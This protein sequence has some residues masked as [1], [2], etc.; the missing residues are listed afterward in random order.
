[1]NN[2]IEIERKYLLHNIDI[3]IGKYIIKKIVIYQSYHESCG[4]EI[5]LR[6]EI[7]EDESCS[8]FLTTKGGLTISRIEK[9]REITKGV[10]D[11]LYPLT[12]ARRLSKVRYV[13]KFPDIN[14]TWEIDEFT[15]RGL[16]LAEVE[17]GSEDEEII[18]PDIIKDSLVREVTCEIKYSNSYLATHLV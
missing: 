18:I 14:R 12:E 10:Y 8:Y 1:M 5:R 4:Y 16:T 7:Y 11:I 13:C 6:Q 15:D 9:E 17:L 3:S 2:D